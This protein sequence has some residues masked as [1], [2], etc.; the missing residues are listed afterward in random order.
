M[1]IKEQKRTE[2]GYWE[3]HT[4]QALQ[5]P[6]RSEEQKRT[7]CSSWTQRKLEMRNGINVTAFLLI[8]WLE[9]RKEERN[10]GRKN[11][12]KEVI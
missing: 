5:E 2:A 6:K 4:K 8:E 7:C 12:K 3:R 11:R 10:R 9:V 1:N